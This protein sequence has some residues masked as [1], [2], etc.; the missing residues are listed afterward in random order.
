MASAKKHK[1]RSQRGYSK[2]ESNKQRGFII[3]A[4]HNHKAQK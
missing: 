2:K 4:S 3:I 1:E